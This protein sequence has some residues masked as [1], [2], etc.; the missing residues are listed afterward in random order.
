[1]S[2]RKTK[3]VEAEHAINPIGELT[4]ASVS[5]LSGD[6]KTRLILQ[7]Q[8]RIAQLEAS[9]VRLRS[10]LDLSHDSYWEQDEQHRFTFRSEA[11]ERRVGAPE[12]FLG[13]TRWELHPTGATPGQWAAHRAVLDAHLPFRDFEYLV[14]FKDSARFMY[15]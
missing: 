10:V 5:Q 11:L 15:R 7:L 6:A 12:S 8:E 3:L 13:K 4:D 2:A 1:M 9:D 14:T